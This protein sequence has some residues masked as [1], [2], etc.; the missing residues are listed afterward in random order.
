ML[1]QDPR[2]L[3]ENVGQLEVWSLGK[4]ANCTGLA[5]WEPISQLSSDLH[6]WACAPLQHHT[7]PKK[8]KNSK[9]LWEPYTKQCVVIWRNIDQFIFFFVNSDV[10]TDASMGH[11]CFRMSWF[12]V[13]CCYINHEHMSRCRTIHSPEDCTLIHQVD[14]PPQTYR[15]QP[16]LS[17]ASVETPSE[18]TLGCVKLTVEY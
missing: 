4:G 5:A 2:M 3:A 1:I 12:P 8:E 15:G 6:K 11:P 13:F 10:E 9:H 17:N 14:S 16:D 7:H 18:R